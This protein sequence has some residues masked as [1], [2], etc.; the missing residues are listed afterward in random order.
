MKRAASKISAAKTRAKP[1]QSTAIKI[2]RAYEPAEKDDGI[3]ILIDRLWPRGLSKASF[4]FDEWPK[5]LAP[6]N[7]LRKWYGHDPKRAAEFRRRYL[8]EL[9][10]HRDALEALKTK[11]KGRT[12]TLLTATREIDLSHA[13]V[14]REVLER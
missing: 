4:K 7:E 8:K 10:P 9:A 1:R 11:L 3:R 6:S 5:E 14:L 2:K 12:A 13:I